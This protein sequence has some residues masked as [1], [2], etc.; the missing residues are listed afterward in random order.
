MSVNQIGALVWWSINEGRVDRNTLVSAFT[1]NNIPNEYLPR[2]INNGRA[3]KRALSKV[4]KLSNKG[5]KYRGIVLTKVSEDKSRIVMEI[6]EREIDI[7][8]TYQS[9]NMRAA[10]RIVFNKDVGFIDF[11]SG[12]YTDIIRDFIGEAQQYYQASD[13]RLMVG[14]LIKDYLGAFAC[15]DRGAVYFVGADKIN[16]FADIQNFITQTVGGGLIDFPI[17]EAK[18]KEVGTM[19]LKEMMEE[20]NT[21]REETIEVIQTAKQNRVIENRIEKFDKFRNQMMGY[22]KL[23]KLDCDDVLAQAQKCSDILSEC[24]GRKEIKI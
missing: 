10:D 16:L 19:C 1:N 6:H 9:V 14:G 23:L 7:E 11:G 12:K 21:M 13:I 2:E 24:L 4:E 8:D 20:F 18:I 15:R 5:E 3:F 17:Y 22:A